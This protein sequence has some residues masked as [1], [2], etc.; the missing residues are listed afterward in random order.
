MKREFLKFRPSRAFEPNGLILTAQAEG[1][2]ILDRRA[3]SL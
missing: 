3:S 2:G 1:L